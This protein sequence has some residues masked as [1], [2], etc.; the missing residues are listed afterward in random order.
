MTSDNEHRLPRT[1]APERYDLT[2]SPDIA[3][4]TFTG[5]ERVLVE[6][7]EPV[8]EIVLNAADLEILEAELTSQDGEELT[9]SVSLDEEH[10]RAVIALSGTA[11]A[12]SWTLHL[13][14]KGTLNDKL[15]G[16]YRS[17]FT[18]TA[19]VEHQIA[20]TQ[21][22]AT[23]ARRAFPC[24]D[25]PDRKAV[26]GVTLVV[27]DGLLAVSN[28]AIIEETDLGNGKRQ[29]T[30]A[31]SM[32]M[33]TYLVAFVV[34]PLVATEPV[35]VDGVPLRIICAA[36][37]LHLTDY[38]LESGAHS[39]R[40]F[41][42]YF[43][44]P[45]PGD[46]LDLIAIPDF[47]AGAM[48]NLGAVT[49]REAV[50]LIDRAAASRTELQRVADVI[51][52]EIAH[53]WFGDLVTMKWW[54][55]IWLNEA[56][57]TFMEMLA[58]DDFQ[59]EWERWVAFG[60][61]KAVAMVTDGLAATRTIEY[62]VG[63]PSDADGMFDS[64]T[65][66][67]GAAVLR[68]LEQHIGGDDFRT[69][70]R[71]YLAKYAYGNTET[72]DLWDAIEAATSEPARSIMDSWI[73]QEGYP[74]I[75]VSNDGARVSLTQQRFRYDG[76]D[77]PT[78]WQVPIAVRASTP[79]GE[80]HHRTLLTERSGA[81]D[82]E[83]AA[84]WIVANEGGAGFYRVR[85]STELLRAITADLNNVMSPLERLN[86]VND[87]WASALAGLG[88]VSD[89]LELCAGLADEDDPNVWAMAAEGLDAIRRALD[90]ETRDRFAAWA[91]G[92]LRPAF[93]RLGWA[94]TAA[95]GDGAG[96]R[97]AILLAALGTWAAD[98]DIRSAAAD[99]HARYLEDRSAIVP[100]LVAAVVTVVAWNGGVADFEQYVERWKRPATPQEETRYLYALGQFRE[101]GLVSRALEVALHEARTQN[102]PFLMQTLLQNTAGQRTAWEFL[103]TNWDEIVERFPG[104][105]LPRMVAPLSVLDPDLVESGSEFLRAHPM[106]GRDKQVDQVL[107]RA[108]INVA[109]RAR[110]ADK[111]AAFLARG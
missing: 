23:D 29:V 39:L 58:V 2:L 78:L 84:G 76:A 33:S 17:R 97:Q 72:E 21:F 61:T 92:F 89:F 77:D 41:T 73:F 50:L 102:A 87:T 93:D 38:A 96:E 80:V 82:L 110:E 13:T 37:K 69:G 91:R 99:L 59:P 27:D 55:G 15:K 70:I 20:T 108:R 63:P 104:N 22:E 71:E 47:A 106:A 107:E 66:E 24:W 4:A 6:V 52:H 105:I 9:G 32:K 95:D 51:A 75:T 14:F 35:D 42:K 40:F 53:M 1:V 31:D 18:D 60:R 26:F 103:E 79:A 65:Y 98:E 10:E 88:P 28:T 25:E 43:G 62:P 64:L 54:N 86:L 45:Y 36:D 16:F 83:G 48:E 111:V 90:D 34:G 81:A 57:A 109:F 94:P 5:E 85:Y 68:M 49:F 46:K 7:L 3:N 19:G 12:G 67:K 44:I 30:F 101:A 8:R 74:L 11:T 100:D 56:F